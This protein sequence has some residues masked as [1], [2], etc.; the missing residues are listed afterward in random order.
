M[1]HF[2]SNTIDGIALL[3]AHLTNLS[4][5]NICIAINLHILLVMH[6]LLRNLLY[7]YITCCIQQCNHIQLLSAYI[8][9]FLIFV[10]LCCSPILLL[11]AVH[12]NVMA[13]TSAA[14]PSTSSPLYAV[15]ANVLATG[16]SIEQGDIEGARYTI[17]YVP[18]ADN[19]NTSLPSSPSGNGDNIIPVMIYCH[20]YRPV[21]IPLLPSFDLDTHDTAMI[22]ELLTTGWIVAATSYRREGYILHDA[23]DDVRQLRQHIVEQTKKVYRPHVTNPILRVIDGYEYGWCY[24]YINRGTT[25]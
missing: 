15:P 13:S 11:P 19:K 18:T 24:W 22:P 25:S 20:G 4:N 23:V 6:H 9:L 14:V 10:D 8:V 3:L 2:I 16:A 1:V 17:A 12:S 21:G 7:I 5:H